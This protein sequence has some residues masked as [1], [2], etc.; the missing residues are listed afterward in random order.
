[1]DGKPKAAGYSIG[2]ARGTV[3]NMCRYQLLHA[4]PTPPESP[5][6]G[7]G[8]A[9]VEYAKISR[10]GWGRDYHKILHKKLKVLANWL[11][12][13]GEGIEA[14]YYADTGPIQDKI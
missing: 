11:R 5:F 1:M 8:R 4:S 14:R 3:L 12:S 2:D 7:E 13:Q 9:G 10:Y 6:G